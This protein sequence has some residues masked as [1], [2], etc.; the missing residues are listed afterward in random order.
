MKS[1]LLLAIATLILA[2]CTNSDNNFDATGKLWSWW[3]DC[4][5]GGI[6]KNYQTWY[7]RRSNFC[8]PVKWWA[9][10]TPHNFTF[11]RSNW[12]FHRGCV[13]KATR[14]QLAALHYSRTT[15]N[16]TTREAACWKSFEGRCRHAKQLDDLNAQ[17]ELL[18]SNTRLCK[19]RLPSPLAL[20]KAKRCPQSP[21]RASERPT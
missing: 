4:F 7:C 6:G 18:K 13:G 5:L 14:C 11:A 17:I 21:T 1:K 2:A 9:S 10:L 3:D 20:C 12:I 19:N 8:K 15:G 16:S